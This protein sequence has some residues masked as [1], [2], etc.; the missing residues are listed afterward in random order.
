MDQQAKRLELLEAKLA[1]DQQL[2]QREKKH[3]QKRWKAARFALQK[4]QHEAAAHNRQ[5]QL[6]YVTFTQQKEQQVKDTLEEWQ[7]EREAERQQARELQAQLQSDTAAAR[8]AAAAAQQALEQI[9]QELDETKAQQQQNATSSIAQLEAELHEKDGTIQTLELQLLDVERVVQTTKAA[10]HSS[11]NNNNSINDGSLSSMRH[12]TSSSNLLPID[13]CSQCASTERRLTDAQFDI[14]TLTSKQTVLDHKLT[15]ERAARDKATLQVKELRQT[16][17]SFPSQKAALQRHV[18]QLESQIVKLT[19]TQEEELEQLAAQHEEHAKEMETTRQALEAL[20]TKY[21]AQ[22]ESL[23]AAEQATQEAVLAAAAAA[24]SSTPHAVVQQVPPPT[25][26]N[27]N[28]RTHVYEHEYV[29]DHCSGIY[30]GYWHDAAP[31]GPGTLRLD[32]GAVYDGEWR[33]GH[34]HGRGVYATIDGDVFCSDVWRESKQSCDT[35]HGTTER[36]RRRQQEDTHHDTTRAATSTCIWADGRVYR[37]DMV[38]GKKEGQGVLTWPYGAWYTGSFV[39]DQRTGQGRYQYPDGRTFVGE[40]HEDRPHGYGVMT[41]ADGTTIL[42]D[43]MW[44]LGEF[45]GA[46]PRAAAPPP[47][48]PA[49]SSCASSTAGSTA[50]SAS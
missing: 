32:D 30:T 45:I 10:N 28:N 26:N 37:G 21:D 16:V 34:F 13:S 18:K 29:A 1:V 14:D 11:I 15:T 38:D 27:N 36:R 33:A 19:E 35:D 46:K 47:A 48:A 12:S 44:Q 20:Q 22:T 49:D 50:T 2:L 31:D 7:T 17:E 43:G 40:Y 39:Q 9:Q 3:A 42:Y 41:A 4:Q 8:A 25:L 24:G 6:D 23:Q 5:R